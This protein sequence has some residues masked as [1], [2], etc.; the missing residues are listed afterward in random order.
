MRGLDEKNYRGEKLH[1]MKGDSNNLN[2]SF[3]VWTWMNGVKT[4]NIFCNFCD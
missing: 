3:T 1:G 4:L 2:R